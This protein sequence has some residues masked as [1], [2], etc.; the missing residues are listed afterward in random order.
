MVKA[1]EALGKKKAKPWYGRECEWLDV[2]ASLRFKTFTKNLARKLQS[3]LAKYRIRLHVVD[4]DSHIDEAVYTKMESCSRMI[5]FGCQHYAEY[6]GSSAATY[7][8]TMY[9]QNTLMRPPYSRPHPLLLRLCDRVR[10][11]LARVLFGRNHLSIDW[12]S[13]RGDVPDGV[14]DGILFQLGRP[15]HGSGCPRA[16]ASHRKCTCGAAKRVI[17]RRNKSCAVSGGKARSRLCKRLKTVA[18]VSAAPRERRRVSRASGAE[19]FRIWGAGSPTRQ[20]V[21]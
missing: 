12:R 18:L 6:T 7:H 9:W 1:C 21:S 15:R 14:L 10:H 5:A 4:P 3:S 17:A 11:R 20:H 8:E 16:D 19:H 2:F 13:S